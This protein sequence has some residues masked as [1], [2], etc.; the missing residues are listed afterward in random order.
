M[1]VVDVETTG[2]NPSS[3]AIVSIGAIEFENPDNQF[4]IENRITKE[5]VV[6]P[7][8]LQ[9]NGLTQEELYD[10]KKPTLKQ[11]MRSFLTWSESIAD[12]TLGGHNTYFDAGFLRAAAAKLKKDPTE[13]IWPFGRRYIDLHSLTY[14]EFKRRGVMVPLRYGF[15]GLWSGAIYELLGMPLE[16]DPHNALTGAKMETEAMGRLIHGKNLL[17]E[18]KHYPLPDYLR[19]QSK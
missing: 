16:P 10:S 13:T 11:A 5:S 4:Y 14:T 19:G 9:I 8:A 17:S 7:S 6:E 3:H 12:K 1:I 15:S 2:T 18:F